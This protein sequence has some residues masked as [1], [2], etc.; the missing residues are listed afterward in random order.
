MRVA[1][2]DIAEDP[3]TDDRNLVL[4]LGLEV[5]QNIATDCWLLVHMLDDFQAKRFLNLGRLS[6]IWVV[7]APRRIAQDRHVCPGERFLAVL[8]ESI[9]LVLHL[10]G[11]GQSIV[12]VED[13]VLDSTTCEFGVVD[14]RDRSGS[15]VRREVSP[16][17]QQSAQESANASLIEVLPELR[18]THIVDY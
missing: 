1:H 16:I 15:D 2:D 6:A 7:F 5:T 10:V 18:S 8:Q 4:L 11:L 17:P 9:V 13:E 14:V 3:V 12:F